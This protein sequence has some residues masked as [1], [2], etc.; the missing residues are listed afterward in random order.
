MIIPTGGSL[1]ESLSDNNIIRIMSDLSILPSL[2]LL[3]V[4]TPQT[5][6]QGLV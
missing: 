6:V 1:A 2:S 5:G 4:V 3:P